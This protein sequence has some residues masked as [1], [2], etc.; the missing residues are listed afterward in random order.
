MALAWHRPALAPEAA[1]LVPALIAEAALLLGLTRRLGW[2]RLLPL[3]TTVNLL[4]VLGVLIRL[5][6]GVE[7]SPWLLLP[8]AALFGGI[9]LG[10]RVRRT[11][12]ALW[13]LL[14]PTVVATGLLFASR[15][16]HSARISAAVGP[17]S[18]QPAEVLRVCLL[19]LVAYVLARRPDALRFAW[20]KVGWLRLPRPRA[21]LHSGALVVIGLALFA[22]MKDLG[23][24]A[25]LIAGFAGLLVERSGSWLYA[26]VTAALAAVGSALLPLLP[27]GRFAYLHGRLGEW[28]QPFGAAPPP[29]AA[30]ADRPG[31][32][33]LRPRR[34]GRRRTRARPG[35][36]GRP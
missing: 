18:F 34:L 6:V 7:P 10:R 14:A 16:V 33:G 5:R 9:S 28:H 30:P 36:I 17:L 1:A 3:L 26:V 25:L 29:G 20:W 23:P 2:E 21:L 35:R 15:S 24:A 19:G 22:V 8:L 11:P 27:L 12:Q 4:V 31:A 32:A 13:W